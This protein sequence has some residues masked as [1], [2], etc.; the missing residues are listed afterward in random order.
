MRR[1]W[2]LFDI[3]ILILDPADQDFYALLEIIM[4][5][6]LLGLHFTA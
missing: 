6:S 1:Q 4:N 2:I 3:Q 5:P